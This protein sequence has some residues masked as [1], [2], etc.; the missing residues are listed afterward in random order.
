MD[1]LLSCL[2][3]PSSCATYYRLVDR[4]TDELE[5]QSWMFDTLRRTVDDTSGALPENSSL[6]LR[7]H[8]AW[9]ADDD[10]NI[11]SWRGP[12]AD[13]F[14][15]PVTNMHS[16][17]AWERVQTFRLYSPNLNLYPLT[18]T[19]FDPAGPS[20]GRV[21]PQVNVLRIT[22][23]PSFYMS[24]FELMCV[25][26]Q[27]PNVRLILMD[28]PCIMIF[29][30]TLESWRGVSAEV[31][32]GEAATPTVLF[33]QLESIWMTKGTTKYD[34]ISC[35]RLVALIQGRVTTAG[36]AE[37]GTRILRRVIVD[38]GV[39]LAEPEKEKWAV[40]QLSAMVELQWGVE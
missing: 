22:H 34:P 39:P 9:D 10:L 8:H 12:Y 32:P 11:H 13:F 20:Q 24:D 15:V 40:Q 18:R 23:R 30:N 5:L 6:G 2:D 7:L 21:L 3:I 29:L 4:D 16:S 17:T 27:L 38:A 1:A 33:P 37:S 26:R 28:A 19:L 35:E 36:T 14:H 25:S 31:V